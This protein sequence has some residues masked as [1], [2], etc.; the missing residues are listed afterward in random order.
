MSKTIIKAYSDAAG[1]SVGQPNQTV[2]V[3]DNDGNPGLTSGVSTK[4]FLDTITYNPSNNFDNVTNYR[5]Q[6]TV[7]GRYQINASVIVSSDLANSLNRANAAL[8]KNGSVLHNG[9]FFSHTTTGVVS[10]FQCMLNTV[11]EFNGTTDYVEVYARGDTTSGTW[12]IEGKETKTYFSAFRIF[13]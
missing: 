7:A 11:V 13:D 5:Y 3:Y 1:V 4:V 12:S 8:F 9:D 2:I 10:S 6:P